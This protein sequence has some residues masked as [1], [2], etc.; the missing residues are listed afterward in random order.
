MEYVVWLPAQH[1]TVGRILKI[2]EDNG[3]KIMA[4][5]S[6]KSYKDLVPV[7]EHQRAVQECLK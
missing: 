6:T 3:W 2:K 1:A 5:Y 7:M 4:T